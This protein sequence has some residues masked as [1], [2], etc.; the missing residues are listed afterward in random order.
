MTNPVEKDSELF[1]R[2]LNGDLLPE[3]F[4]IENFE[5]YL[6]PL[7]YGEIQTILSGFWNTLKAE[8]YILLNNVFIP[9]FAEE[10]LPRVKP[11]IVKL[12]IAKVY[13]ISGLE[14]KKSSLKVLD[15]FAKRMQRIKEDRKE[16]DW[17]RMV[18]FLQK[19]K[20][21]GSLMEGQISTVWE[22]LF[23]TCF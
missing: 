23:N 9:K 5:A 11:S 7:A 19:L 21:D 4:T 10:E 22:D 18:L 12:L 14:F 17:F 13:E 20:K 6:R 3:S 1:R 8:N 16:G 2:D 15:E